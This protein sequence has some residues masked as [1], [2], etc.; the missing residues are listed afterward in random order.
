MLEI[1]SAELAVAMV[2]TGCKSVRDAG[3]D[4]LDRV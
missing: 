3:P 1:I 4:L 2:L